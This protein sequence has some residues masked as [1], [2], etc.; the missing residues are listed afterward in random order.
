MQMQCRFLMERGSWIE[1]H[2][3]FRTADTLCEDKDGL[4]WGRILHTASMVE[5][6]RGWAAKSRKYIEQSLEI[7]ERC[8][9][10]GDMELSSCYNNFAIMILTES[11]EPA[12]LTEAKD[13]FTKA[14]KIDENLPD[15]KKVLHL[16]YLNVGHVYSL[17]GEYGLADEFLEKGRALAERN[18]GRDTH[19]VGR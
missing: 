5:A 18:F 16:R 19:F 17:Q 7:R 15:G 3:L 4:I 2:D 1:F 13:Y 14:I 12:A 9:P 8:C 6:E 10:P 11:E